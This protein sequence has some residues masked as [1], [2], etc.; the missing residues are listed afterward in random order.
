MRGK[1]RVAQTYIV[2]ITVV[3]AR[4]ESYGYAIQ[5]E[6]WEVCHSREI[7]SSFIRSYRK[8]WYEKTNCTRA[9]LQDRL[10][11]FV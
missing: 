9:A 7:L 1:R 6:I 8:K 11:R 5:P 10:V 3:T 4:K 2:E